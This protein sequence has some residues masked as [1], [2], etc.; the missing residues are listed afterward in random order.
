MLSCSIFIAWG[1]AEFASYEVKVGALSSGVSS[2]VMV[3]VNLPNYQSSIRVEMV[4]QHGQEVMRWK[5]ADPKVCF[6]T[7]SLFYVIK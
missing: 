3:S 4:R 5:F 2:Y 7:M 1:S 6:C